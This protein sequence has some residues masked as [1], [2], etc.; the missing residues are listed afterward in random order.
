MQSLNSRELAAVADYQVSN[1]AVSGITKNPKPGDNV[2]VYIVGNV[3]DLAAPF[4]LFDAWQICVAAA[5]VDKN[6]DPTDLKDFQQITSL[7]GGLPV[8][9]SSTIHISDLWNPA[10]LYLSLGAMPERSIKV[11][12]QLF[13]SPSMNAPWYWSL[14]NTKATSPEGWDLIG[15]IKRPVSVYK[16]TNWL[17]IGGIALGATVVVGLVVRKFIK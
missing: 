13:A 10:H 3:T 14:W 5:A 8:P 15:V 12:V 17:L 6:G 1:F 4:P 9:L 2:G 7:V 16:P 11:Q